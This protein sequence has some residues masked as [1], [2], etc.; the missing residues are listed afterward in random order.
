MDKSLAS[1][2]HG[3]ES[4]AWHDKAGALTFYGILSKDKK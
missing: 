4:Q 3:H 2:V 1:V